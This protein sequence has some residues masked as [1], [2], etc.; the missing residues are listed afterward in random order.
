MKQVEIN[1]D[2]FGKHHN[3]SFTNLPPFKGV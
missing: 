2:G 3:T 1:G